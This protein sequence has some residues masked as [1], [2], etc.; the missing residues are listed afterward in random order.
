MVFVSPYMK[1]SYTSRC[2]F[3]FSFYSNCTWCYL[4]IL[5]QSLQ[6]T[7]LISFHIC[8]LIC[9]RPFCFIKCFYT[10]NQSPAYLKYIR[11][12]RGGAQFI[13]MP[14]STVLYFFFFFF[15]LVNHR[16]FW[17]FFELQKKKKSN[18]AL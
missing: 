16:F 10:D 4:V 13:L 14:A 18:A 2:T 6:L 1:N 15:F 17:F 7:T 8:F 3:A 5:R 9:M 11:H 12:N